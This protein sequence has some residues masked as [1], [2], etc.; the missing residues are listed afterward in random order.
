M[1]LHGFV[2]LSKNDREEAGHIALEFLC[3]RDVLVDE[4]VVDTFVT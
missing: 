2:A 4:L 1:S 3:V